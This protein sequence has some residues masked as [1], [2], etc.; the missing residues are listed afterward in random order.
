MGMRIAFLDC[1]AGISGD[2]FLGALIGAGVPVSVFEEAVVSLGLNASLRI[3]TVDRSGISSWK[4]DVY[5]GDSLA[6]APA[7][8]PAH[9]HAHA[10]DHAHTHDHAHADTHA[11]TPADFQ[12]HVHDSESESASEHEHEPAPVH[13]RSHEHSHEHS[14]GTGV[15]AQEALHS[16]KHEPEHA[17]QHTAELA[18]SHEHTSSHAHT[19]GRSLT[20]IRRVIGNSTL[21]DNVKRLALHTFTLLGAAE[22]KIHAVPVDA[23]HFHEVGAVDAI[24]DIVASCAGIHY[25]NM[26]GDDRLHW[27]A[28]AVNVGGGMVQCAHGTFPV[29]APATAELLRGMPTYAAYV[30]KELVTPT[31]AALL[32]ALAPQFGGQ[33]AMS[34]NAIGYGAGTRNPKGFPNVLR[35]Q[36][37]VASAPG[38]SVQLQREGDVNAHMNAHVDAHPDHQPVHAHEQPAHKHERHNAAAHGA[39]RA[40]IESNRHVDAHVDAYVHA[41]A[42]ARGAAHGEADP[43]ANGE[44]HVEAS[45]TVL[46]TALDDCTPQL[47]AYVAERALDAGALDVMLTPVVMKKGRPG[48]LITVLC[49]ATDARELEDL[50]LRETP[51]L[52]VRMHRQH[53]SCLD[54]AHVV[55]ETEFGR[56]RVK[57]GSRAGE[58]LNVTPEFEDCRAA[59]GTHGVALKQ[60]MQAAIAEYA[61]RQSRT[62]HM[63]TS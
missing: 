58:V 63:G 43:G 61:Q 39:E 29:P 22:A 54:R 45:V 56:I 32:A 12:T 7:Q 24:V 33:P 48:T 38:A 2:M 44:G 11:P 1:F 16:E 60:V 47:L 49:N 37:G 19:H 4:V 6:E 62:A 30:E 17:P 46:E 20:E 25:L 21:Q 35:L 5:E 40:T 9:S 18:R 27:H 41:H 23:I 10:H 53:R 8:E 34:T 28:S 51:T 59:A 3:H 13:E 31:G 55:V 50:L 15:F 57:T 42:H 14:H 36:V 26:Q 52:G